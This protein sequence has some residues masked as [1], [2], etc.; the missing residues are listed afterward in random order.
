MGI[1][2]PEVFGVVYAMQPVGTGSGVQAFTSRPD[3]T[4]LMHAKSLTEV[5]NAGFSTLFLSMFQAFLPDT[6]HA[7]L[8]V[9][10][11]VYE[12]AGAFEVDV[13]RMA[14]LRSRFFISELVPQ[15]LD[16]IKQL[17]ALK[18][19]WSRNDTIY[20]HVY[21][22]QNL[23]HLLNEYG[24]SHEAEEFNGHGD[25]YWGAHARMTGEVIPF[26]AEHLETGQPQ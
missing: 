25:D 20:D 13:E 22:N 15:H 4:L 6:N 21:S 8:Y 18:I 12:T 11:P 5:N 7:P 10:L 3:W 1:W 2:H 19:D 14:R 24:I 17:R 9:D 26:L 23:T 16:Q